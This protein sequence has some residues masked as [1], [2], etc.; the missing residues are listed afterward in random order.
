MTT[1]HI[2]EVSHEL[3]ETLR[4]LRSRQQPMEI[5]WAR[6]V[7]QVVSVPVDSAKVEV[8]YDRVTCQESAPFLDAPPN[9]PK[10]PPPGLEGITTPVG[11][12][13][14]GPTRL[15]S[16]SF[17]SRSRQVTPPLPRD[18][19]GTVTRQDRDAFKTSSCSRTR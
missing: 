12:I 9:I 6:A 8:E 7:A 11:P 15:I 4:S 17:T 10:L 16:A 5:E 14:T 2:D 19:N 13:R 3:L 18:A 1:P